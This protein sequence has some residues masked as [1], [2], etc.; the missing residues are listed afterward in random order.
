MCPPLR[1]GLAMNGGQVS[2]LRKAGPWLRP[3]LRPK[4]F[5]QRDDLDMSLAV[6]LGPEHEMPVLDLG[7]LQAV[8]VAPDRLRLLTHGVPLNPNPRPQNL[9]PLLKWRQ[10]HLRADLVDRHDSGADVGLP[11]LSSV[12]LAVS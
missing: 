12:V 6:V 8:V 4:Q 3:P 11:A 9:N 5:R 10:A 1:R 7:H 2:N